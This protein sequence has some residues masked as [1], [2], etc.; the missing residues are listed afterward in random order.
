MCYSSAASCHAERIATYTK[1]Y[2]WYYYWYYYCYY[3]CYN[4]SYRVIRPT[5]QSIWHRREGCEAEI[6]RFLCLILGNSI[7]VLLLFFV[8]LSF[9]QTY[10]D[11]E[12]SQVLQENFNAGSN[13]FVLWHLWAFEEIM[14]IMITIMRMIVLIFI[15]I[16]IINANFIIITIII[17]I[18]LL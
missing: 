16:S 14:L 7:T 9:M 10:T 5:L 1:C 13:V 17:I 3:Y 8:Y 11:C 12:W 18:L 6:Y 15:I 2:Y 4:C